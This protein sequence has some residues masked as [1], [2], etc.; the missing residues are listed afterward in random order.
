M[1]AEV[2]PLRPQKS[3][4]IS[5]DEVPDAADSNQASDSNV[6]AKR[7]DHALATSVDTII[8]DA[9]RAG[10]TFV[11]KDDTQLKVKPGLK[12]RDAKFAEQLLGSLDSKNVDVRSSITQRMMRD[13]DP[14]EKKIHKEKSTKEKADFRLRWAQLQSEVYLTTS[15]FEQSWK[16]VDT[17]RG[18]YVSASKYYQLE[19]GTQDDYAPT[20][21]AL[22]KCAKM[23]WPFCAWNDMTCRFDFLRLDREFQ[24]DMT[25]AWTLYEKSKGSQQQRQ[26]PSAPA[27]PPPAPI[28]A[29]QPSPQQPERGQK[30]N[31]S[32]PGTTSKKDRA[33]SSDPTA[34]ASSAKDAKPS[35]ILAAATRMKAKYAIA[36]SNAT[37][38]R[39]NIEEQATWEW[40]KT[41]NMR[42]SFENAFAELETKSQEPFAVSM[43]THDIGVLKKTMDATELAKRAGQYVDTLKPLVDAVIQ[44]TTRLTKMHVAS[45]E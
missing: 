28:A 36:F 10:S 25:R 11:D 13:L 12:D 33:A 17:T 45:Q 40:A 9:A 18:K 7:L 37:Q 4:I 29:A 31:A 6:N 15:V 16:R 44:H 38:L 3:T 22:E 5:L 20:L 41:S 42:T 14:A 26:Q 27:Q 32:S 19:G 8:K 34:P 24:E 30:R 1:Q 2:S 23:G 21:L 43:H 35:A 39:K